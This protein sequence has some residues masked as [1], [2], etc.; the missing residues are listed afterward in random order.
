VSTRSCSPLTRGLL[1]ANTNAFGTA[2]GIAMHV[3]I[4]WAEV[5]LY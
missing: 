1:L 3:E 5:T 2:S 4:Y